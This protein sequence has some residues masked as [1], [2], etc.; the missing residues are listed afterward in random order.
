MV[1]GEGRWLLVATAVTRHQHHPAWDRP[2]LVKARQDVVELFTDQFGY[3]LLTEIGLDPTRHQL[4]EGLRAVCSPTAVNP[5]GEQD[6]LAVYIT[7]HGHVLDDTGEHVLITSDTR[8][9]DLGDTLSTADLAAKMLR[10]TMVRRVLQIANLPPVT[11]L[12]H[13]H[14]HVHGSGDYQRTD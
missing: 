13:G 3:R 1:S 10:G 14:L 11:G 8:P 5:I 6:L 9:D 4:A 7:C 12:T 2:A